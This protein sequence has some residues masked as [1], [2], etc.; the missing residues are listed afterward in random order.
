MFLSKANLETIQAVRK[1]KSTP[2]LYVMY[3]E[4]KG[5]TVCVSQRAVMAVGP[6]KK[7]IREKL[8]FLSETEQTQ[9]VV[10]LQGATID[11]VLKNMPSD[12]MFKGLLEHCDINEQGTAVLSDGKMSKSIRGK[13]VKMKPMPYRELL[14]R[15]LVKKKVARS[16]VNLS[17]LRAMLDSIEKACGDKSGE[18]P[19]FIEFSDQDDI[20]IRTEHPRFGQR[21]IG[22]MT[23]L[24]GGTWLKE[25]EW[26]NGLKSMTDQ[27]TLLGKLKIRKSKKRKKLRLKIK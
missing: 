8:K 5:S 20:I 13:V 16:A 3:M 14:R 21:I 25:D 26:E 22:I 19:I 9:D 6:V 18:L 10:T 2:A 24:R 11:V 15:A 17:R 7:E 12:T 1:D 4:R 27:G 23:A